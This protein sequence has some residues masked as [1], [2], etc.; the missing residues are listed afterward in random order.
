M[1]G[2]DF[3]ERDEEDFIDQLD[4]VEIKLELGEG[5]EVDVKLGGMDEEGAIAEI[6]SGDIEYLEEDEQ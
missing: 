1:V 4:N 6:F 5:L 3:D 2:D